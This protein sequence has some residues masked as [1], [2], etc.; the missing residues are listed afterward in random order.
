LSR[1][2]RDEYDGDGKADPS[3]PYPVIEIV[4]WLKSTNGI[5][6]ESWLGSDS[7]ITFH[8]HFL[9]ERARLI[10]PSSIQTLVRVWWVKSITG[11]LYELW[12]G[13]GTY[14]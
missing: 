10:Q 12:M 9:T 14:T 3:K 13:S 7:L 4:W 11:A 6:N 1:K 5:W 2:I 8:L